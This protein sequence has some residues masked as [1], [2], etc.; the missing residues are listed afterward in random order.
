MI[1]TSSAGP[2]PAPAAPAVV[3]RVQGGQAIIVGRVG[4]RPGVEQRVHDTGLR[5]QGPR[6]LDDRRLPA[7]V[8]DVRV[9]DAEG[10]HVAHTLGIADANGVEEATA[11]PGDEVHER[12]VRCADHS[13]AVRHRVRSA[14]IAPRIRRARVSGFFASSMAPTYSRWCE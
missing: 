3:G 12:R 14:S 1:L 2:A 5:E 9:D 11:I 6:C 7:F 8:A 4:V 10:E 13:V